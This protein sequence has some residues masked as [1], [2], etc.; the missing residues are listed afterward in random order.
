M[1]SKKLKKKKSRASLNMG[2]IDFRLSYPGISI[3]NALN[4]CASTLPRSDAPSIMHP[5]RKAK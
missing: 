2:G 1:S 4:N 5:I 3:A